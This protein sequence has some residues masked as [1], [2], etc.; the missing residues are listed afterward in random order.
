MKNHKHMRIIGLSGQSGSGKTSLAR[1]LA[2]TIQGDIVSF[3]SYVRAEAQRCGKEES[4]ST[5]Q[6]LGQ[7]L[8]QEYGADVFVQRVLDHGKSR[9]GACILL[10]GVRHVA[11]WQAIQRMTP[12]NV[13]IFISLDEAQRMERLRARDHLDTPTL[14]QIMHHSIEKDS[15]LLQAMADLVL[16]P[17][18]TKELLSKVM[19]ILHAREIV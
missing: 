12:K 19:N 15:P 8:I 5:L 6:D 16:H 17:A 18:S 14:E 1:A 2:T 3:G 11:I 9:E 10:D 13:L 7:A 4:R